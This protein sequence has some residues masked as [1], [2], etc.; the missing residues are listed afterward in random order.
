[1][2]WEWRAFVPAD[3]A[4]DVF[5]V[6]SVTVAADER[7][8]CYQPLTPD[9]G[10]KRRGGAGWELKVCTKREQ[11]IEKFKKHHL[12]SPSELEGYLGSDL[13]AKAAAA[14]VNREAWVTLDKS[15]MQTRVGAGVG[16][17][18][19]TSA[20][21]LIFEQT[22]IDVEIAGRHVGH[23]RSFCVEGGNA[24]DIAA[25]IHSVP[26]LR[27]IA[28]SSS[29]PSTVMG[30]PAFVKMIARLDIANT[31]PASS[32]SSSSSSLLP[33]PPQPPSVLPQPVGRR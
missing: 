11:G 23:W 6:L 15:R 19:G 27:T 33:S 29:D 14:N 26:E 8:D 28:E 18:S 1:M 3:E 16:V 2:G 5:D 24:E 13:S 32:S 31:A 7:S 22:D 20:K 4:V 21:P 25:F 17:G 12:S 10:F 9:F 30:Y